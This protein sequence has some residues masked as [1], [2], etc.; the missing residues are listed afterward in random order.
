MNGARPRQG[1]LESLRLIVRKPKSAAKSAAIL[2]LF[3]GTTLCSHVP[4]KES[5]NRERSA[6]ELSPVQAHQTILRLHE[7]QRVI[8][9]GPSDYLTLL[10]QMQPGDTLLLRPGIY[11]K[12]NVQEISSLPI[13]DLNGEPGK[14]IVISGPEQGALP[15]FLARASFN[16]VRIAR[17]SYVTVRNLVLDGQGIDADGVKAEGVS[18]HITI[19]NLR[20]LNHGADQS[21]VGISTKAPAWD[22]VIRRNVI[23][24]AGTGIY[25]GNSDGN[26]PFIGGIIENNLIVD[27]VGYD[28]EIKHQN[29][30][31][32]LPGLSVTPRA[33]IIRHN[34]F[35]KGANSSEGTM[36]RPNVLVGHFPLDGPGAEDTY[37]V[38][39]NLF[40]H[41]PSGE[42]LFQ[43]EGNVA[44]YSNLF[45]SPGGDGVR[46]QPHHDLP[47]RIYIFFNTVVAGEKGIVVR[48]GSPLYPQAVV[49]NVVF[50]VSPLAAPNEWGNIT[51]SFVE[52]RRVLNNPEGALGDLDLFP[53]P[54]A[55]VGKP[56]D[57]R[58][59]RGFLDWD[60]DF[61]GISRNL[62]FRGAYSGEGKNPGWTPALE[63]KPI[64]SMSLPQH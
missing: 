62:R 46:I 61:N 63:I 22:W 35:T 32:T 50:A 45:V 20:I 59:F 6:E 16:T 60:R 2:T 15:V 39:G 17:S 12:G 56:L 48:G 23:L 24:G 7:E 19:E 8:P 18:H 64:T 33:T 55:A 30:R 31:P 57:A 26:A 38:Y 11:G 53:W 42:A 52:E 29:P 34:V 51:G 54:G 28:M 27:S 47:R 13:V 10:K 9:A 5:P 43:A 3:V 4:R 1:S 40:Y 14:P 44:L 37:L 21:T 49:G 41:N 58:L 25:L 36:A